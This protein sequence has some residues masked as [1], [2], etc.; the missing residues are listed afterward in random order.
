MTRWRG[1]AVLAVA[2]ASVAV[3]SA[4][5]RPP[6]QAAP[7]GSGLIL[8]RVVDAE[9]T[10]PI[11]GVLL[12]LSGGGATPGPSPAG[13]SRRLLTDAQGRFVFRN[14]PKGAYTIVA[15]VGGNGFSPSGFLISGS[16]QQIGA[17]LNGGFGQRRPGGALQTIDLGEGERIPD[18]VIRLWK[19]GAIDGTIVDEV[20]E[21]LVG[22][23]DRPTEISG[24]LFD[25]LGRPTHEYAV[26]AFST[27]RSD[28]TSAPRRT[29]GV[30]KLGSDGRFT[31]SGLP[32]GEYY[33]GVLTDADPSQLAD[34]SFLEQLAATSIRITLGEGERKVQDIKMAGG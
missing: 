17:Y 20:G 16:G 29:S 19:G 31:V 23:V 25:Q 6:D 3:P 5:Q 27:E 32:P 13:I 21:P 22:L 18:A 1:I 12:G 2:A 34:L 26:V 8:G 9:S 15:T 28:W 33:L 24:T 30:V 4:A 14:L 7:A 11:S 10:Q